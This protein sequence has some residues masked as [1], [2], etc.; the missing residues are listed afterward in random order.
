MPSQA[1]AQAAGSTP[2]HQLPSKSMR[3]MRVSGCAAARMS[4]TSEVTGSCR[5]RRKACE[6][7]PIAEGVDAVL[8]EARHLRLGQ[9]A[10]EGGVEHG[11]HRGPRALRRDARRRGARH[12]VVAEADAEEERLLGQQRHPVLLV[13]VAVGEA[14]EVGAFEFDPV[15]AVAMAD[16]G[17]EACDIGPRGRGGRAEPVVMR[18]AMGRAHHMRRVQHPEPRVVQAHGPAGHVRAARVAAGDQL[19][20]GSRLSA[21]TISACSGTISAPAQRAGSTR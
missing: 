17:H 10:G 12:A 19:A 20:E 14:H 3:R 4:A 7:G 16:L 15:G 2:P 6:V 5:Q 11:R 8:R 21:A 13:V 18:V 1:A 9:F